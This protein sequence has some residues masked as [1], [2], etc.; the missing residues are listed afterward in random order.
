[1]AKETEKQGFVYQS[2]GRSSKEIRQERGDVIAEDL[3]M[4]FKRAVEDLSMQLKRLERK[5]RGMYDF[6]PTNSLSLV[7]T[8]DVDSSE[9]KDKDLELSLDIRNTKIQ[10][11]IAEVRYKELFF[12]ASGE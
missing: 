6:S 1:M 8:K 10:L 4:T 7:M 9:I 3:E 12:E 5:R 2:L 11:E